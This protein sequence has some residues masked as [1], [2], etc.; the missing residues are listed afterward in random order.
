MGQNFRFLDVNRTPLFNILH[1]RKYVLQRKLNEGI[2]IRTERAQL[3]FHCKFSLK[4]VSSIID[5]N[6]Y[7][8]LFI[9]KFFFIGEIWKKSSFMFVHQNFSDTIGNRHHFILVWKLAEY[10]H[11]LEVMLFFLTFWDLN[12]VTSIGNSLMM[13]I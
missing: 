3:I 10:H 9:A 13:Y 12:G 11:L 1:L 6:N 2:E 4:V 7:Q 8:T 5:S